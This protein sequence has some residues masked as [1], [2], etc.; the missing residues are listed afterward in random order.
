MANQLPA[1][2]AAIKA[3]QRKALREDP[4]NVQQMVQGVAGINQDVAQAQQERGEKTVQGII[5]DNELL[6]HVPALVAPLIEHAVMV[7]NHKED[8]LAQQLAS[9]SGAKKDP[10]NGAAYL[11]VI[12][13]NVERIEG[14]AWDESGNLMYGGGYHVREN[15]T[16][17]QQKAFELIC[18]IGKQI[19]ASVMS[20]FSRNYNVRVEKI[21]KGGAV[22]V[23]CFYTNKQ[24][25]QEHDRAVA[26]LYQS[27][28]ENL[29][30]LAVV[31]YVPGETLESIVDRFD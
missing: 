10:T 19:N 5:Q 25:N 16:D 28:K 18:A 21:E 30:G 20:V 29:I 22:F 23:V 13:H 17:I 31:N 9:K 15:T 14:V 3:L 26:F 2:H 1:E 12:S 24:T 4:A 8:V 7:F 27:T 11:T 6:K